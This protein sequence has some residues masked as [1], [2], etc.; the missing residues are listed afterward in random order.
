MILINIFNSIITLPQGFYLSIQEHL[1]F[2]HLFL[3]NFPPFLFPQQVFKGIH[4]LS[5]LVTMWPV[6][7]IQISPYAPTLP[8]MA[9]STD[10]VSHLTLYYCSRSCTKETRQQWFLHPGA[11]FL[12][13]FPNYMQTVTLH[14]GCGAYLIPA[15]TVTI[16]LLS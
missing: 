1:C 16:K 14:T 5:K 11:F 12:L 13:I 9:V 3:L 10:S 4:G 8:W 7:D 2:Y 6:D 15:Q